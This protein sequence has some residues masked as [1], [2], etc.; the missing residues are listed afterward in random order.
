[1]S[2]DTTP[3]ESNEDTTANVAELRKEAAKYRTRAKEAEAQRDEISK[4]LSN[5]QRA[6]AERLAATAT[7]GFRPLADGSDLWVADNEI[8]GLVGEDGTVNADAVRERVGAL[9][10]N[11]PHYLARAA[12]PEGSADGGKGSPSAGEGL[13]FGEAI[14]SI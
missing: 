12:S 9:G 2:D 3:P 5:F 1:M 8:E 7:D 4:R 10:E 14:K 13:S 6:E 11:R